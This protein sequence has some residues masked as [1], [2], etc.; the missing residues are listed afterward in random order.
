[1]TIYWL[2][3]ADLPPLPDKVRHIRRATLD[4]LGAFVY[5]QTRAFEL[6]RPKLTAAQQAAIN[7]HL[8]HIGTAVYEMQQVADAEEW[9]RFSDW[10]PERLL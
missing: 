5:Q 2:G 10:R 4:R 7:R 3:D 1:M 9:Q 8:E 6:Q